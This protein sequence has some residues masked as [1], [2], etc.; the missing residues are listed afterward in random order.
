MPRI[1]IP[2]P[3]SV[4]F[5]HRVPVRITDLNYGNHLGH[6]A[7][8]SILHEARARFFRAFGMSEADVDG[9]GIILVDLAVRYQ[10]QVFY[11]QT[12]RIEIAK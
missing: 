6:D 8:V 1:H 10:A 5:E 9:V 12:L 4:L 2:F 7:L 11:G 3:E